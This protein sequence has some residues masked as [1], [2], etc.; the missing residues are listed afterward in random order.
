MAEAAPGYSPLHESHTDDEDARPI[1]KPSAQ[2]GEERQARLPLEVAGDDSKKAEDTTAA[3]EEEGMEID[4]P[5]DAYGA[6]ILAIIRDIQ[7]IVQGGEDRT[8]S[9]I[10]AT[11]ALFLLALNLVLQFSMI[12]FIQRFVV[13]PDVRHVQEQYRKFHAKV[14]DTA[15]QFHESFWEEYDDKEELCQIAMTNRVF[16]CSILLLWTLSIVREFRLSERLLRDI[17]GMPWCSRGDQMCEESADSCRVVALTTPAKVALILLVCIPKLA[18]CCSLLLLGCTWLSAT[19]SFENLVMNTVAMEF[20]THID[21]SLYETLLP[22]SHRTQVA[23]VNFHVRRAVEKKADYNGFGRSTFYLFLTVMFILL[24]GSFIQNVLP[25]DLSDIKEPCKS[26][27]A[28]K[29][30]IC[31]VDWWKGVTGVTDC[32]PYG[33]DIGL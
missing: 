12:F 29:Q 11:F 3:L 5:E 9:I 30:P 18:I 2:A 19:T 32:F 20:V 25:P 16:Y 26:Y 1:S 7:I 8:I 13:N 14:F 23:E 4:I 6:A 15:G 21:E 33:H 10:Q 17:W 24:F 31:K 28:Q 27:L 22:D